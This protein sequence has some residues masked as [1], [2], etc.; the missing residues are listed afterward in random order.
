VLSHS[1]FSPWRADKVGKGHPSAM[2]EGQDGGKTAR[3]AV[4]QGAGGM[5]LL[6]VLQNKDEMMCGRRRGRTHHTSRMPEH[7]DERPRSGPALGEV[8]DGEGVGWRGEV[9]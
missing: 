8:K 2:G 7:G 9:T 1:C 6:L 3:A 4:T 5:T